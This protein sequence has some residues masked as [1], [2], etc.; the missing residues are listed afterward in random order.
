MDP[1]RDRLRAARIERGWTQEQAAAKFNV[2]RETISHWELGKKNPY[3][4]SVHQMCKEYDATVAELDL[5]PHSE[6]ADIQIDLEAITMSR[7]A[8]VVGALLGAPL[9]LENR[10]SMATMEEAIS[11]CALGIPA[12][13]KLHFKGQTEH[14][15]CILPVYQAALSTL[16]QQSSPL[17]KQV[18]ALASQAHQLAYEVA[19]DQ[20]DYRAAQDSGQRAVLYAQAAEDPHMLVASLIH[21]ADCFFHQ[22]QPTYA[23]RAYQQA[24]PIIGST[25]SLLQGRVYAGM[26]EVQGMR[27]EKEALTSLGLAHEYYP[28]R[29]E[30]DPNYSYTHFSRYSLHVFGEGQTRL[31]LGQPKEA[32]EA[33]TYAEQ[34]LNLENEPLTRLDLLYYQTTASVML[35]DLEQSCENI[36]VAVALARSIGSRLY[37]RKIA[38]TFQTMRTK[39]PRESRISELETLFQP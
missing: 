23:L 29:P 4:I 27:S 14:V 28:E 26:A 36:K 13:W 30:T 22:K 20:E 31:F 10:S 16:T 6:T 15:A 24:L 33:F 11:L 25:T 34:N 8:V 18:L 12:C 9:A 19:V 2:S 7:R 21:Q 1:K 35:D 3:P 37:Y 17:Q 38:E 39:W 32:A 5:A